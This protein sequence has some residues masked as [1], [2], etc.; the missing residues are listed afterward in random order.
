VVS[1]REGL[2]VRI[3]VAEDNPSTL[4]AL[5]H[6]LEAWG[7]EVVPAQD[8]AAAWQFFQNEEFFMVISDWVMPGMDG[9]ELVRHIRAHPR[10]RYAFIILL[11]VKSDTADLVQGI[12]AG[13]DDFITKPFKPNE[14]RARLLAGE[15]IIRLQQSLLQ[16]NRELEEA[17]LR[18][19]SV[20][21]RLMEDRQVAANSQKAFFPTDLPNVPGF[22]F[23]WVFQPCEELAGDMFN[24]FRLDESHIALY[25]LDVSGH[26]VTAALLAVT[27]SRLL[28]PTLAKP[29]LVKERIQESPGYRLVPPAEV[30]RHLNQQFTSSTL[31]N[32]FFTLLYGI[33]D[34]Q[35]KNFR[36]VSA[37]HPGPLLLARDGTPK[38]LAGGPP[39]IG[40]FESPVYP[41]HA[42]AL[43][44]GDRL[45]L[46][47]D[48]LLETVNGHGQIF[49]EAHLQQTLAQSRSLS[50]QDSLSSLM[51]AVQEWRGEIDLTDDISVL[52]I[53]IET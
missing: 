46:Y 21:Q 4:Q 25:L 29:S 32:Q 53:E 39:A 48:G 16:R 8:G 26:G 34:L 45:Y 22:Q 43:H 27:L 44:P 7:H 41:E 36:Y 42:I 10:P 23:A 3:L 2:A 31:N 40:I 24:V 51:K 14:L 15:R 47:S 28:S 38:V 35:T 37:G 1:L 12:E 13:A 17:N 50:L 19:S 33:L 30:A 20:N 9:L 18:I 5:R 11:T 52:A 49:G 6:H